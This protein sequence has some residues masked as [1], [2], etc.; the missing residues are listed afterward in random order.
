M[1]RY[2]LLLLLFCFFN[3]SVQAIDK[4]ELADAVY[5]AGN[6]YAYDFNWDKAF[7]HYA[8]AVKWAPG[9]VRYRYRAAEAAL[10]LEK[11]DQALSFLNPKR[12]G[13]DAPAWALHGTIRLKK[14]NI[15]KARGAFL[16]ALELDPNHPEPYYGLAQCEEADLKKKGT[17]AARA[18]VMAN[19]QAYLGS[20][21]DGKKR[22]KAEN[23]LRELQYGTQKGGQLNQAIDV[24]KVQEFDRA[25]RLL[26]KLS[27]TLNEAYYWLGV[28]AQNRGDIDSALTHWEN[29]KSFPMA[30]LK[31]AQQQMAQGK[32]TLAF[33]HL[34]FAQTRVPKQAEINLA[35]GIVALEL[36]RYDDAKR[37]LQIVISTAPQRPEATAAL[38]LLHQLSPTIAPQKLPWGSE[39][40]TETQLRERYGGELEAPNPQNRLESI[41]DRLQ[42]IPSELTHRVFHVVILKSD[43]PNAFPVM[44]NKILMTQGLIKFVETAP[45]L[46][47]RADDALAFI[48][49]HEIA[50]LVEHH[51][52]Q[53]SE[54]RVMAEGNISDYQTRQAI[55]HRTEFHADRKGAFWA[56][57]AKYDPFV[58]VAWCRASQRHYKD[59]PSGSHHPT[60]D[61][62]R[63]ALTKFLSEDLMEAFSQFK[64]GVLLLEQR[65]AKD[66][67]Y[68]FELYLAY[69]PTDTQAQYNVAL[70]YFLRGIQQLPAPPWVPWEVALGIARQP[71]FT[72]PKLRVITP[73]AEHWIKRAQSRAKAVLQPENT[74]ASALRLLGDI[75][76][77]YGRFDTAVQYYE[78]ALKSR[79][80]DPV[81]HNN[82]GVVAGLKQNRQEAK[83]RF[84]AG[85]GFN[86][87]MDAIARGNL[88]ELQ[89]GN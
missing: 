16:K 35:L 30:R 39:S 77:A 53:I 5:N 64:R 67:A 32:Y 76:L 69:L 59:R 51:P 86:A 27:P 2:V 49:G 14:G 52:E 87:E 38:E 23:R 80:D 6:Q 28:I 54:L 57:Q 68:A 7:E 63:A 66:A 83:N 40:L 70:A 17:Q 65:K 58:A 85:V 24:L 9:V 55:L 56:Y 47:N 15:E 18:R 81:I 75:E 78:K 4:S 46:R 12:L 10:K 71:E 73:E 82:L 48:L 8:E 43:I 88:Q 79:P 42:E 36:R 22:E 11:I 41:I 74:H 20:A 29:A 34:K 72:A 19:Y 25:E 45:E 50:H 13:T 3:V 26:Q 33:K 21:P 1:Y 61:Q 60:F 44:P 84:E 31:I 89:R 62:R 37:W